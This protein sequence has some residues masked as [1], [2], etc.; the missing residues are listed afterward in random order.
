[1]VSD[2]E[3][4][5]PLSPLQAG[6]LFHAVYDD[7]GPDVYNVQV[8]FE[9]VG[10]WD[11][12]ALRAAARTLLARH[13]NLR[14]GFLYEGLEQPVQVVPKAVE[15]PWTE[16][17]LRARDAGARE[18]EVARLLAEDRARRFDLSQP[19]LMRFTLI[20]LEDERFRFVLTNHHILLDGWSMPL[21]TRELLTLYTRRGDDVGLPRVTPYRDYLAWLSRQDRPAALDAWR[22]SLAGLEEPTRIAPTGPGRDPVLPER[23]SVDLSEELTAA[24][25]EFARGRSLTMNTVVQVAWGLLLSRVT[26]REDVVFGATVSG[27][28]PE[29]PGI[30]S[31]VGLFINTLP[32]RMK[33]NPAET[34]T[35]LLSRFQEEQT[36]L[37]NHQYIGLGEIQQLAG[38]GELFDTV[39][40]F[41]NYP[42]DPGALQTMPSGLQVAAVQGRDATHYPLA[43]GVIPGKALHLRLDYRPDLF[44][45]ATIEEI[46]QRLVRLLEAIAT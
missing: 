39:M 14:A 22:S 9:L 20:R 36:R 25:Q 38:I 35:G 32:V 5:L 34:L 11:T 2:L 10:P 13:A 28:P 4:I 24:L 8:A 43:L 21:V 6:L 44:D 27:R 31:M 7:Q 41:E 37:I 45:K 15:L 30:E 26:G 1:M 3:D 23:V 40:V 18:A 46:V 33:I 42:F 12:E 29:L 19:P 16:V 17:D